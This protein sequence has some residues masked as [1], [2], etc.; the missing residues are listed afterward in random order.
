MVSLVRGEVHVAVLKHVIVGLD[1]VVVRHFDAVL[2]HQLAVWQVRVSLDAS[3]WKWSL[4]VEEF[5][6]VDVHRG[7]LS[8]VDLEVV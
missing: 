4:C 8:R 6:D 3:I 1:A 7:E 2:A 5:H